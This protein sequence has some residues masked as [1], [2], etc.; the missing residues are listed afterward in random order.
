MQNLSKR[1]RNQGGDL[2]EKHIFV[3]SENHQTLL[4][5]W[6]ATTRTSL[7][8]SDFRTLYY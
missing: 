2:E 3:I 5:A 6:H 1:D 7:R 8:L 4:G